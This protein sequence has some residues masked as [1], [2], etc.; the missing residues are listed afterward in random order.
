M[1]S[2]KNKPL[3]SSRTAANVPIGSFCPV[4]ARLSSN[5]GA[6][7]TSIEPAKYGI[8]KPSSCWEF[9]IGGRYIFIISTVPS[10]LWRASS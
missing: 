2:L 6:S 10:Y 5:Q 7:A 1:G 8:W 4:S 9:K 3:V